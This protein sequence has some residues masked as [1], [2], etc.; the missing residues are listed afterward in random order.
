MESGSTQ[1]LTIYQT[2]KIRKI[3]VKVIDEAHVCGLR[4]TNDKDE[5]FVDLSF[6]TDKSLGEW[7][8]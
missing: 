6:S 5:H 2:Q 8:E 3:S 1:A 4:L 7:I